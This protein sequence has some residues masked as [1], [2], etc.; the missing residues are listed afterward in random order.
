M[1][2][3]NDVTMEFDETTGDYYAVWRPI[4]IGSGSSRPNWE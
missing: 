1:P 4:V 3:R 2:V